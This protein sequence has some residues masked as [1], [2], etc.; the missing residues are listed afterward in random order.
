MTPVTEQEWESVLNTLVRGGLRE[1]IDEIV[2]SRGSVPISMTNRRIIEQ[3]Y[4]DGDDNT[5]DLV[6]TDD[7]PWFVGLWSDQEVMFGVEHDGTLY[8]VVHASGGGLVSVIVGRDLI[9]NEV[10]VVFRSVG[11]AKAYIKGLTAK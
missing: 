1:C 6:L 5:V 8:S 2:A 11:E 3:A 7:P 9:D 10:G 4:D